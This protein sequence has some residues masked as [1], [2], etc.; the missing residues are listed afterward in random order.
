VD[1]SEEALAALGWESEPGPIQRQL[2]EPV[3]PEGFQGELPQRS[4]VGSTLLFPFL[5]FI[6]ISWWST[7]Y[8]GHEP[9]GG[10]YI[11]QRILSARDEKN[12]LLATLLFSLC[13]F[14][15]RPWPWVIVGL[16][17]LVTYAQHPLYLEN[18]NNGYVLAMLD[19]LGPGLLGLML[20]SLLAA[21]M[22]TISTQI[23]WG[24]SYIVNDVYQRF[25]A[26]QASPRHLVMI[27][28]I[29]TALLVILGLWASSTIQRIEG[30]WLLVMGLGAGTGLVYLL[31]WFWWRINAWS[32]ISSMVASLV[33]W[34]GLEY[35]NRWS[36][37]ANGWAF[38]EQTRLLITVLCSTATW[39][40]V[41]AA[42]RPTDSATLRAFYRL[43]RPGG[44][45]WKPIA[46]QEPEVKSPDRLGLDIANWVLGCG[47]IYGSLFGA[48][49]LM[50]GPAGLGIGLIILALV[51]AALIV[52]NFRRHGFEHFAR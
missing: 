45:G 44:P 4:G 10:G 16:V 33:V 12:S 35:F 34:I 24:S 5:F 43:A 30:A 52:M 15:L 17:A 9:G 36:G 22:S 18:P 2:I 47:L 26:P 38:N 25:V 19:F 6:L 41:T 48:W 14:A 1:Y 3:A 50:I 31:R 11:A 20:V 28:R 46:A 29:T 7:W 27:G 40:I 32:E 39:L 21:F 42:T 23:N 49:K 37:A 8:P 51:C 13:H